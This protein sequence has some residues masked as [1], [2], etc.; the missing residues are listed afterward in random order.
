MH[1]SNEAL[2]GKCHDARYPNG[3]I[4]RLHLLYAKA[5]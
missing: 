1:C 3:L 2:E 4:N 5:M